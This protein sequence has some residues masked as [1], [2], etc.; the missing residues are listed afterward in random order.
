ML[1]HGNLIAQRRHCYASQF[2]VDKIKAKY[3]QIYQKNSLTT[4]PHVQFET[5]GIKIIRGMNEFASPNLS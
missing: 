5:H 2:L 3:T 1:R 4:V